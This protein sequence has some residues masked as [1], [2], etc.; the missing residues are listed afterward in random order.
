MGASTL[1]TRHSVVMA[2]GLALASGAGTGG[3]A[4]NGNSQGEPPALPDGSGNGSA[5]TTCAGTDS[6]T[7]NA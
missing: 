2:A 6:A 1:I 5:T 4:A 7:V 3:N